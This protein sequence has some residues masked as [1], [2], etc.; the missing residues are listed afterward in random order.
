MK[1]RER[2]GERGRGRETE[3]ERERERKTYLEIPFL[4]FGPV[5]VE[6]LAELCAVRRPFFTFPLLADVGRVRREVADSFPEARDEGAA[7]ER[8]RERR[9]G[10]GEGEE[11]ERERETEREGRETVREEEVRKDI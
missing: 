4:F 10:R 2:E 11:E 1:E 5:V 7:R 3:R 9:G 8:E 6:R